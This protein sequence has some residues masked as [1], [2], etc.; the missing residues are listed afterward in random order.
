MVPFSSQKNEVTVELNYSEVALKLVLNLCKNLM[1][2]KWIERWLP[3]FVPYSALIC[4]IKQY[5]L[6]IYVKS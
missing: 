2:L 6:C 1:S 5:H 4:Y 3:R